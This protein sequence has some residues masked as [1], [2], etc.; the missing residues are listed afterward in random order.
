MICFK[1]YE[2]EP[3]AT[4]ECG[5]CFRWTDDGEGYVG[6]VG[7]KVCRIRNDQLICPDCDND[8]WREYFCLDFDYAGMKDILIKSDKALKEC[9]DFGKGIRILKQPLWETVVSFI[10][11]ANNNIPRIRKIIDTLCSMYGDEVIFEGKSYYTFPDAKRLAGLT[12]EDL[13]P[14]KAGYRDKYILDAAAK[15]ASGEIDPE[16]LDTLTLGEVEKTLLGIK[17]VGKKVADCIMLFSLGKYEVF[18][19]DVW[20]KRIMLEVYGVSE[21][22]AGRFATEKFGEFAGFAQQYLFYYYRENK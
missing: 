12:A 3:V 1:D 18:P 5:Q 11:S 8:F 13:A 10:I 14:L 20:I 7:D 4:F 2:F 21:N 22:Q 9:I 16:K 17:G 6:I 19:Q 15:F